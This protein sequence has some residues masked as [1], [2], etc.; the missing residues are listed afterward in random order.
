ML[1]SVEACIVHLEVTSLDIHQVWDIV[2]REKM[3]YPIS[4]HFHFKSLAKSTYN[5]LTSDDML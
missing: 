4:F 2:T 5:I 3:A 1:E